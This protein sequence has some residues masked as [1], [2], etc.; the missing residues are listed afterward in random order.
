MNIMSHITVKQQKNFKL[1]LLIFHFKLFRLNTY[2][3]KIKLN[4][5][6]DKQPKMIDN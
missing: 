1:E 6:V 4:D 3:K 2:I 5:K